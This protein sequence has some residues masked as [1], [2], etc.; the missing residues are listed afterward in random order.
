MIPI[1][2]HFAGSEKKMLVSTKMFWGCITAANLLG[3]VFGAFV[4]N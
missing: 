4:C 2:N 1:D 3:V